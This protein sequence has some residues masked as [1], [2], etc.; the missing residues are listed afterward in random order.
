MLPSLCCEYNHVIEVPAIALIG[1]ALSYPPMPRPECA[2]DV[3]QGLIL[4]S[5]RYFHCLRVADDLPLRLGV[6]E[7]VNVLD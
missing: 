3:L 4:I 1:R 7:V 5:Q 2:Q 6:A